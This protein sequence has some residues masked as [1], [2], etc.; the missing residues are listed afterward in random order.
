MSKKLKKLTSRYDINVLEDHDFLDH[1]SSNPNIQGV[2]R[3]KKLGSQIFG[4]IMFI[5]I[6]SI[7]L[8]LIVGD[9]WDAVNSRGWEK[10]QGKIISSEVEMYISIDSEGSSTE[11][12]SAVIEY[13]YSINGVLYQNSKISFTDYSTSSAEPMQEIVDSFPTGSA[14]AVYHHP[15]DVNNVVIIP[16][17]SGQLWMMT[18]FAILMPL[19]GIGLLAN[20]ALRF[21]GGIM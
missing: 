14:V 3:I 15:N 6:G 1:I 4:G 16:G 17:M 19:I 10:V 21:L 13:N 20:G 9:V 7:F 8:V 2:T 18:G 5:I 12:Y 11:M